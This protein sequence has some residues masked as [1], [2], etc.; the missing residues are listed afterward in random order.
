LLI[1]ISEALTI[2]GVVVIPE[3]I[4]PRLI[5]HSVVILAIPGVGGH[6]DRSF[7]DFD[8]VLDPSERFLERT[9]VWD[10][11]GGGLSRQFQFRKF[12]NLQFR[13]L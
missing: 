4:I 2:L 11:F 9:G 3:L 6:W 7:S 10:P 5:R 12:R 8:V 1:Y 13:H